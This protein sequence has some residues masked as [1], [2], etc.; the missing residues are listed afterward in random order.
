[1]LQLELKGLHNSLLSSLR[2]ESE[3]ATEQVGGR[4]SIA[5]MTP[6]KRPLIGLG[7]D[8]EQSPAECT[9]RSISPGDWRRTAADG[10]RNL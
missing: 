9:W 6:E 7:A 5:R 10:S 1:M 8:S 3:C 4:G 2:H